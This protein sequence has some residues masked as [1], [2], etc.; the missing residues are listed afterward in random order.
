[1][2]CYRAPAKY[3]C[4]YI[5]PFSESPSSGARIPVPGTSIRP[6]NIGIQTMIPSIMTLFLCSTRNQLGSCNALLATVSLFCIL[7]LDV[8]DCY[9]ATLASIRP[10]DAAIQDIVASTP[11]LFCVRPCV[12]TPAVLSVSSSSGLYLPSR[13]A[14][15]TIL[16]FKVLCHLFPH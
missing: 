5:A 7:Q 14:I 16:G 11:T 2:K 13:P 4:V 10:V 1:M 12:C 9:P 6:V 3:T 15:R 8:F